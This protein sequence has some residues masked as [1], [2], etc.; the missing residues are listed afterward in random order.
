MLQ[1]MNFIVSGVAISLS[2][3]AIFLSRAESR[4]AEKNLNSANNALNEITK[5]IT[6]LGDVVN[7]QITDAW[8]VFL[9]KV[10]REGRK[11][12]TSKEI[13]RAS[14]LIN[15]FKKMGVEEEL[16]RVGREKIK[17]RFKKSK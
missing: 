1:V 14:E 16:K 9:E 2:V 3:V 6:E 12:P 7:K 10:K 17:S 8:D 13:G 5:R 15:I 4:R 11:L